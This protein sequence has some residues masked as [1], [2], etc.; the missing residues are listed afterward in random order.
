LA[1]F[2]DPN[3]FGQI[4]SYLLATFLRQRSITQSSLTKR[5]NPAA[6]ASI[7]SAGSATWLHSCWQSLTNMMFGAESAPKMR[8]CRTPLHA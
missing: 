1:E 3:Q 2:E 8:K 7:T 6:I 5:H 4:A